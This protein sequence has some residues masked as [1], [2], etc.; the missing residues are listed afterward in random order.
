MLHIAGDLSLQVMEVLPR[1]VVRGGD[2]TETRCPQDCEGLLWAFAEGLAE[3]PQVAS[4]SPVW[5]A[6]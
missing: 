3:D 2:I 1:E 5:W 6:A 4:V